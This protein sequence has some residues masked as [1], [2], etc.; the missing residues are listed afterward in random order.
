MMVI[1]IDWY[2]VEGWT[3]GSARHWHGWIQ[4]V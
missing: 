2:I 3:A 1:C 4:Q